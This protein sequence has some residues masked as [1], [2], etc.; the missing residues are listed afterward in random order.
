MPQ[1]NVLILDRRSEFNLIEA[2][3]PAQLLK[4]LATGHWLKGEATVRAGVFF[5]SETQGHLRFRWP[6]SLAADQRQLSKTANDC[7][8]QITPHRDAPSNCA[9]ARLIAPGL[10]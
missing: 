7:V 9:T 10:G 2:I 1:I 3:K 6:F 4:P 8:V 5:Y